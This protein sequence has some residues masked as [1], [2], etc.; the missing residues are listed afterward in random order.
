MKLWA[1]YQ[2]LFFYSFLTVSL[3]SSGRHQTCNKRI[4]LAFAAVR[5]PGLCHQVQN[6]ASLAHI[7][8][9]LQ[10]KRNTT[11]FSVSFLSFLLSCLL[12][13]FLPFALSWLLSFSFWQ[14]PAFLSELRISWFW[15]SP[16]SLGCCLDSTPSSYWFSLQST[17]IICTHFFNRP[18]L[19][20]LN[21]LPTQNSPV[22]KDVWEDGAEES[23]VS[24]VLSAQV[25]SPGF[26]P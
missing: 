14:L 7:H 12:S 16:F 15:M 17:G 25:S 8:I 13:L 5:I 2:H 18:W 10:A 3:S 9:M 23:L 24:R 26:D 4:F 1:I 20:I 21:H 22:M 11:P 19:H 6:Q